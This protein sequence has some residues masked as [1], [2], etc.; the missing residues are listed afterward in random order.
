MPQK[1][2]IIIIVIHSFIQYQTTFKTWEKSDDRCAFLHYTAMALCF[3]R[4]AHLLEG[5]RDSSSPKL[6]PAFGRCS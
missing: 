4:L 6:G 5:V 1:Q 3:K 2:F